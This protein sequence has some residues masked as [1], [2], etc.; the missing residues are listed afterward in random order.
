MEGGLTAQPPL[1]TPIFLK[2]TAR[3]TI[4]YNQAYC[5]FS[6]PDGAYGLIFMREQ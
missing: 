2:V 4:T 1:E 6:K 5:S 3:T